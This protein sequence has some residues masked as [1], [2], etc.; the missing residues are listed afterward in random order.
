MQFYRVYLYISKLDQIRNAIKYT[1]MKKIFTL[2]TILLI[3]ISVD[4]QILTFE[5]S[6][7][8]GSE[9]SANSNAN[10][11]NLTSSTITRG[12]GLTSGA[13]GGRFNSTNITTGSSID[14]NDYV[15]FTIT[16]QATKMFSISSIVVQHQR[17]GTGPLNFALRS[18]TD[19]YATDLGGVFAG[20]DVATTQT[21]TYTFTV[22]NSTSA[23]TFRMYP[24]SSEAAAGT[25]GPGDGTGDDI[26]VNGTTGDAPQPISL[27][28]FE[29][30]KLAEKVKISWTTATE[31][32][33]DKFIVER[34]SNGNDFELVSEIKGAGNSK[35]LN[36]YELID[37]NP[38]KGTS[39]YR[40]TQID[41]DGRLE[42]FAPVA[43]KMNAKS[44]EVQAWSAS[45]GTI[46]LNVYSP[47]NTTTEILIRDLSGRTIVSEKVNL[48]EGYQKLNIDANILSS[49]VHF[50]QLMNA[51]GVVMKKLVL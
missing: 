13:N 26:I 36:T 40:L 42:S 32:N 48:T 49:G 7:L 4:A 1:F 2:L 16:P 37:E 14:V 30:E 8:A 27:V 45:E 34:S 18:S 21:A 19:N 6:A 39:Y 47:S 28:K 44:L 29:A 5:F 35:E 17:S 43:V 46:N 20:T 10:N 51:E 9:T 38:L 15:E 31:I 24:Y 3:G 12:S 23:I 41:F 25:W 50:I 11:A 33:N 22:T